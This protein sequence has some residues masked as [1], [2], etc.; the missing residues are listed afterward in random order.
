MRVLIVRLSAMGDLVHTLPAITDAKNARPDVTIDWVVDEAFAD[1]PRMHPGVDRIIISTLRS[2]GGSRQITNFLSELRREKYDL[3]VDLQG[4]FKSATTAALAR[5]QKAGYASS[6][7]H[8]W[9]AHVFYSSK[10]RVDPGQHSLQRMRQL[11]ASALGYSYDRDQIDYGV[12][13]L[14]LPTVDLQLPDPYLVF[15]H[16]TSWASKNWPIDHWRHLVSL[17]RSAGN[18]VVLPWGSETERLRS[19]QL[20]GSDGG[21]LVLPQ[22]SI[23]EKAA[24]ISGAAGTIGLDTGLSH[25]AAAFDIPSVTLYG[26]TDPTRVGATGRHQT[27]LVPD[28]RCLYCHKEICRLDGI[29]RELPQC[30]DR[31]TATEVWNCTEENLGDAAG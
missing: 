22:M 9:G 7:I 6:D 26:P 13:R 28:F 17:A 1:V 29:E 20:A 23:A 24:I 25:I 31:V 15:V 12:S 4:I 5:G 10:F 27:H 21:I 8:E 30:L 14:L 18:T 19:V 2:S 16:S 11:L 3:I